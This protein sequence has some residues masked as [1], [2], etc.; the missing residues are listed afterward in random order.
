M[1]DRHTKREKLVTVI[2]QHL[3][4]KKDLFECYN[5]YY[6]NPQEEFGHSIIEDIYVNE[7]EYIKEISKYLN[8]WD[9]DR[10]NYVEQAVLLEAVSEI[11]QNINDKA[12]IIDEAVI[13]CQKYCDPDTYKYINGVLDN[14]CSN[15][16]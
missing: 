13:I 8:N 1:S 6:L 4:L 12:V 3:L 11:K 16:A 5:D 2:Y 9:F 7:K 15:L 10:L 14:L